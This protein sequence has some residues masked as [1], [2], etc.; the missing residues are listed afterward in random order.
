MPEFT[1]PH[2]EGES[3][4][5]SAEKL[6]Q[7][8]TFELVVARHAE[9]NMD[10][11]TPEKLGHLTEKGVEQS[12]Q[13]GEQ[14]LEVARKLGGNVDIS[15]IASSQKYDS[16]DF[17]MYEDGGRRAEETADEAM[18][19]LME[20]QD[21]LGIRLL[22]PV[23]EHKPD[24]PYNDSLV[25]GDIYY[26]P[27]KPGSDNEPNEDPMAYIKSLRERNGKDWKEVH[28]RGSDDVSE[29]VAAGIGAETSS[30]VSGRTMEVVED[31]AEL[32][33]L[34]S[35]REPDRKI[36]FVM[37]AH[38][39]VIRSLLQNELG[40]RDDSYNYLP[41]HAESVPVHVKNG[42]A[43]TEFGGKEYRTII[44]GKSV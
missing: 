6:N 29:A 16:P 1:S 15:F 18:K 41:S 35:E 34:H 42:V 36:I 37:V 17:P 13:L 7:L 30:D 40:V 10:E 22:S 3:S 20:H 25:E 4:E 2:H 39:G 14:V 11:T 31:V 9:Y 27:F 8:P 32:A 23:Y 44:T 5:A 43:S 21:E 12:K 24:V 38:D 26:I 28:L 19:V 33:R